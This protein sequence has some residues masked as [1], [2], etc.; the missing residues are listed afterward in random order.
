M[1][2]NRFNLLMSLVAT[3]FGLFWLAWIL[4]T[5]FDAG[6]SAVWSEVFTQMT[7]PPGNSGGLLNAITGSLIMAGGA[8]LVG[9]PIGVLAGVYLA[10]FGRRGQA[11]SPGS[12]SRLRGFP[13]KRHHSF[14]R[15]STINSGVPISMPPWRTCPSSSSSSR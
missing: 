10:E 1:W 5:L 13:G 3:A 12:C 11:Y 8:T 7:P 4:W 15:R 14:S 6:L 2:T 9:T